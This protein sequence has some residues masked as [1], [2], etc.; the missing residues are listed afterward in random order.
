MVVKKKC[1]PS[2]S[3]PGRREQIKRRLNVRISKQPPSAICEPLKFVL[4]HCVTP[5]G[6][7]G[8]SS[9]F[10]PNK[11]NILESS[12]KDTGTILLTQI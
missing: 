8:F 2:K 5:T 7:S 1:V 3:M 10:Q 11:L 6:H 12:S 4:Y 9:G